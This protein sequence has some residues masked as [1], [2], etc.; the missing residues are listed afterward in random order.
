MR[1]DEQFSDL[2][3]RSG[4]AS[5]AFMTTSKRASTRPADVKAQEILTLAFP[6]ERN[7]SKIRQTIKRIAIA[8]W[9]TG[10]LSR[11]E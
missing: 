10:L 7:A 2:R 6:A 8:K 9:E 5:P 3:A 4:A 11:G 1:D